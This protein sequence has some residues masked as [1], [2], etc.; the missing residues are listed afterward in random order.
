MSER[1]PPLLRKILN[2]DIKITKKFV[3]L[4]NNFLPLKSLRVHYKALEISCHGIPW[5]AFWIAFTWFFNNTSLVQLQVNMLIGLFLDIVLI[6]LTKAFFR[7]RRPTSNKDDALGQIGPDVFSFPSG[8]ASRAAMVAFVFIN[9]YPLPIFCIP[10]LLAWTTSIC[11]SRVLMLRHHLLDVA[12]GVLL[13][14]LE[15]VILSIIWLEQSTAVS[16]MSYISDEKLDGGE[17]HV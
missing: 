6:A 4:A 9:L 5:F 8:H 13:G 7:R 16:L 1:V 14:I 12:A 3:V 10:P 11:I 2:A 15:G 17:F